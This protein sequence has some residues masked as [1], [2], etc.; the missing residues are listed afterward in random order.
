MNK[1]KCSVALQRPW[2][3]VSMR[4]R[5]LAS[6]AGMTGPVAIQLSWQPSAPLNYTSSSVSTW[7]AP[8]KVGSSFS[9]LGGGGAPHLQTKD[10]TDRGCMCRSSR[11]GFTPLYHTAFLHQQRMWDSWFGWCHRLQWWICHRQPGIGGT[12][13]FVGTHFHISY[14]HELRTFRALSPGRE[15]GRWRDASRGKHKSLL[16][17]AAMS[18]TSAGG[19]A[20]LE[21]VG[22]GLRGTDALLRKQNLCAWWE[23]PPFH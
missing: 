22:G 4:L 1:S 9:H 18:V 17:V 21:E 10:P 2:D 3:S 23:S 8:G 19:W 7:A 13:H 20:G 11:S 6:E 5:S 16:R 12:L 15:I 14:S